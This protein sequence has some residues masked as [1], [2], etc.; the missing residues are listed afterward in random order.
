MRIRWNSVRARRGVAATE[1]AVLAPVLG[2]IALGAY[3]FGN[4]VQTSIRLDRAVRT[5]AQHAVLQP[6]DFAGMRAAA[7]AAWPALTD[8]ELPMPTEACLCGGSTVACSA[9]CGSGLVR[10]VTVTARRSVQPFILGGLAA[11]AGSATVRVQ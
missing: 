10:T 4:A 9:T 6:R 3:D 8:A 5:G 7:R 11:R 2:L 1:F